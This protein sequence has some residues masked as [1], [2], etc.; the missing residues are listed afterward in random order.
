MSSAATRSLSPGG[1]GPAVPND[2]LESDGQA[3]IRGDRRA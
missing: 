3:E 1:R 2:R